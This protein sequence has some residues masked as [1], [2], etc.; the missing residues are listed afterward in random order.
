MRMPLQEIK[1]HEKIQAFLS[2]HRFCCLSVVDG[3]EPYTVPLNYGFS[4]TENEELTF[5]FHTSIGGHLYDVIKEK[6][7]NG[8]KASITI[9]EMAGLLKSMK[10]VCEWDCDYKSIMAK[11]TLDTLTDPAERE[12]ALRVLMDGFGAEPGYQFV[13]ARIAAVMVYRV[14]IHDFHM[15]RSKQEISQ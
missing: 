12:A 5:Y 13:P 2:K 14:K 15:K 11:G 10:G 4:Y 3:D 8:I 1:E 6:G 7:G 9:A